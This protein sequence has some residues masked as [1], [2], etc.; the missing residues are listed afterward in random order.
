MFDKKLLLQHIDN[1]DINTKDLSERRDHSIQ[2]Q[3]ETDE[4]YK[5]RMARR[6]RN[7]R[8][9]SDVQIHLTNAARARRGMPPLDPT[10]IKNTVQNKQAFGMRTA[11]QQYADRF[12]PDGNF[13]S[14]Y[15]P[16]PAPT[17]SQPSS[18]RQGIATQDHGEIPEDQLDPKPSF[19]SAA[20]ISNMLDN[21][22]NPPEFR[23]SRISDRGFLDRMKL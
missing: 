17:S 2:G 13:V 18:T 4:D 5:E 23:G 16:Q 12:G 22:R 19:F 21:I 14:N 9:K 11:A 3:N 10:K 8:H 1:Q 7:E 20:N 15:N 6:A